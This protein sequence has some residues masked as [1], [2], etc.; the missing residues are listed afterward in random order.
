MQIQTVTKKV[1]TTIPI[2]F[3]YVQILINFI[4][5]VSPGPQQG[6]NRQ[7]T[8]TLQIIIQ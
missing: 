5:P 1:Q 3:N 8:T 2:M 7:N 6:K 4:Q